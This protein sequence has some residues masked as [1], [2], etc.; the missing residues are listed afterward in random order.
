MQ[1][2]YELF[3]TAAARS[4]ELL[5]HIRKHNLTSDEISRDL[6]ISRKVANRYRWIAR[7]IPL[8]ALRVAAK[9]QLS[10]EQ[11]DITTSILNQVNPLQADIDKTRLEFFNICAAT[12]I[13]DLKR[14]LAQKVTT[15][16]QRL[17][18]PASPR[19]AASMRP[20]RAGLGHCHFMLPFER[21]QAVNNVL[22]KDAL[23]LRASNENL[24]YAAAVALA[25]ERRILHAQPVV[26]KQLSPCFLFPL[27]PG[28]HYFNDGTVATIDG[29][30]RPLASLL[31]AELADFGYAI[32]YEL[33]DDGQ[34]KI[35]TSAKLSRTKRL[36]SP[37]QKFLSA[38]EYLVCQHPNCTH[39]AI[40]CDS[41][42]LR[43]WSQGG[44]TTQDNC[45]PLCGPHN[46]YN[47]DNPNAPPRHGRVDYD[48][49]TGRIGHRAT[50]QSPFTYNQHPL[51]E[52]GGQFWAHQ[53]Y[54]THP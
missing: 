5:I 19:G 4:G 13:D 33:D 46:A 14:E 10:L 36:F 32:V 3:S 41:H 35:A 52:K 17:P 51:I 31:D 29:T 8:S 9:L 23:S 38:A 15:L 16:N 45:V 22:H 26:D 34:P 39:K 40:G 21:H 11:L 20:D 24:S 54:R 6:R 2:A 53:Y 7:H 43:A 44:P 27:R 47:D 30:T 37:W 49:I 50:P 1:N 42:H 28:E 12:P 25:F 48:P 18:R